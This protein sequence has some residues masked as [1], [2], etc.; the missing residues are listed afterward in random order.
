MSKD[1]NIGLRLKEER[2][3]LGKNQTDF[4]S[5][6]GFSRRTQVKYEQGE[7]EPDELYLFKASELGVDIGYVLDGVKTKYDAV[8]TDISAL[9][10]AQRLLNNPELIETIMIVN[11]VMNKTGMAVTDASKFKLLLSSLAEIEIIENQLSR[12]QLVDK[13]LLNMARKF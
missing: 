8:N 11:E 12:K 6:C 4:A 1:K 5:F 7:S 10:K 2:K 9:P 3:R 13:L